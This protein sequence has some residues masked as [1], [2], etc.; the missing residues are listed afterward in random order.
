MYSMGK[1]GSMVV[2]VNQMTFFQKDIRTSIVPEAGTME[3]AHVEVQTND[4]KHEDCKEKQQADLQQ[5]YHGFHDG[6]QDHLKT[7]H[8]K[9]RSEECSSKISRTFTLVK[10]ST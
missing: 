7:C 9:N 2:G 4:G 8:R 5:R 10:G 3:L 1:K 6:L